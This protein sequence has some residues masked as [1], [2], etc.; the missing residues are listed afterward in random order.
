MAVAPLL[1]WG[2]LVREKQWGLAPLLGLEGVAEVVASLIVLDMFDY[3]WHRW[4]HRV[5][6]LWRFHKVHHVDTQ[7]D[8][9]TALRF[10]LGEL[11]ISVVVKAAWILTWGPTLW[12]LAIFEGFVTLAAQFHHS[13]IDFPDPV[14]R[15]ARLLI[16]TPRFHASHHTVSQRTRD[17]NFST[18]LI[19]WDKLFGTFQREDAEEM[20]TLGLPGGRE[21]YLSFL[22]AL[23]GPFSG[24][25]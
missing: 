11:L 21:T 1:Y 4:N 20:R 23:K 2:N 15:L 16:V 9:T 10:H 7:V 12:S 14:E 5:P 22:S 8:V 25:Y 3:W 17:N 24:E 6:F 13:N 19:F 18:I